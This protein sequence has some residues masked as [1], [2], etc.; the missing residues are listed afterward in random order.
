MSHV[1]YSCPV[2]KECQR[3]PLSI[4][5][6]NLLH[7]LEIGQQI[8]LTEKI[9][10]HSLHTWVVYY[11]TSE[12]ESAVNIMPASHTGLFLH[13]MLSVTLSCFQAI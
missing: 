3:N 7:H 4:S 10:N 2:G 5:K 6:F 12:G 1:P 8:Q 13:R 9:L 11:L